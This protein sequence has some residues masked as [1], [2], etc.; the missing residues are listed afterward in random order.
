MVEAAGREFSVVDIETE[1]EEGNEEVAAEVG[2][3]VGAKRYLAARVWAVDGCWDGWWEEE[4]WSGRGAMYIELSC[5]MHVCE[6]ER[7][8][9]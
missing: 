2:E 4:G 7:Q 8:K 6:D 9:F 5:R 3:E 1:E